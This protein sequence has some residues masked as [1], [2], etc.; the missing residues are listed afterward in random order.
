M[1]LELPEVLNA[2]ELADFLNIS[3][4]NAYNLLNSADF[5]T[6]HVG[7]RKMVT[8]ENLLRWMEKNTNQVA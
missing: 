7:N 3:R 4:A 1:I 6:L 5:P 8:K 2:R